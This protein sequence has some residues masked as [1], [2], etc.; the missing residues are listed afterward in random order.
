MMFLFSVATRID[1][2]TVPLLILVSLEETV[3][4]EARR[5]SARSLAET[6]GAFVGCSFVAR[7]G[8]LRKREQGLRYF[9]WF[10]RSLGRTDR[11]PDC[12][13]T[14]SL[15]EHCPPTNSLAEVISRGLRFQK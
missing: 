13:P 3:M 10:S 1:G 15:A 8:G 5:R 6:G 12:K 14:N 2:T 4:R 9:F 11:N 7:W